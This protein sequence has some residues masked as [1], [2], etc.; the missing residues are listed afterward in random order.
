MVVMES[1]QA[2][3]AVKQIRRAY[4]Y[5]GVGAALKLVKQA[6]EQFPAE[7]TVLT[8]LAD[9]L[10]WTGNEA[11]ALELLG[12]IVQ[13]QPNCGQAHG[14]LAT[15]WA[16]QG[17]A[18]Q[19]EHH[20]S[21]A[22]QW[23]PQSREAREGMLNCLTIQEDQDAAFAIAEMIFWDEPNSP[24][25]WAAYF[26]G[27]FSTHGLAEAEELL[28]SAPAAVKGTGV[29]LVAS[30]RVALM[31]LDLQSGAKL[32]RAATEASPE[33]DGA[34]ATL[35]MA[36]DSLGDVHGAMEAAERALA[37]N[38]KE[39]TAL[40]TLSKLMEA[41]GHFGDAVDARVRADA[42]LPYMAD[43]SRYFE[44][45][46]LIQ[47]D[48]LEKALALAIEIEPKVTVA[49][50]ANL[51][52]TLFMLL[53]ELEMWD[54]LE[55]R[56]DK[57]KQA[58]ESNADLA[59]Y[60]AELILHKQ[61]PETA[62]AHFRSASSTWQN[63]P[64]LAGRYLSVLGEVGPVEEFER[65]LSVLMD[66][67]PPSPAHCSALVE[68]LLG[69]GRLKAAVAVLASGTEHFPQSE[70]LQELSAILAIASMLEDD[71]A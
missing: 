57:A 18:E 38:P 8:S 19:S 31:S 17:D 61:G 48:E 7:P 58:G 22:M 51:Q 27:V 10:L 26:Y 32:A 36:L 24:T 66:R 69:M 67:V 44:V 16:I 71:A 52:A 41:Q 21:L 1:K 64:Q 40:R 60:N 43:D 63:S 47:D 11:Q 59:L 13:E 33:S 56:I 29:F 55:S 12:Q 39:T 62:L 2:Q 9:C 23:A 42:A 28:A 14:L 5:V 4:D 49:N 68:A 65:E 6:A 35:A 34:W 37:I 70:E 45:L 3:E 20:A 50:R 46:E 53:H 15:Y 54:E 25:A 30:A